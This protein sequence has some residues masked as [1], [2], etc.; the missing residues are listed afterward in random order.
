MIFAKRYGML[1]SGEE[2]SQATDRIKITH[3]DYRLIQD[4]KRYELIDGELLLTPAPS[5]RHQEI[6]LEIM[7]RLALWVK[8]NNLGK[9]FAAPTDVVLS[10]FDVVQ[11][12]ILFVAKEHL[13][14]IREESIHGPPDL[15][16]EILSP[17][18]E[19]RDLIIKKQLYSTYGVRE[20]WIVDPASESITVMIFQKNRLK[21]KQTY[22][23]GSSVE[24]AVVTG[25]KLQTR[26]I[27]RA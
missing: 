26:E 19:K 18:Q 16:I 2:M 8:E 21:T 17:K 4:D 22:T 10:K 24:S 15:V 20:Y 25:F 5:T 9:V 3:E 13:G 12:D 6:S 27:F 7:L 14:M 23:L 11:P 1:K